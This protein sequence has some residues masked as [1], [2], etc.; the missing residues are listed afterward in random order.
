MEVSGAT[1]G[2]GSTTKLYIGTTSHPPALN[3]Q[4]KNYKM[5]Y[6]GL[7][8][9]WPYPTMVVVEYHDP[10]NNVMSAEGG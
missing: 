3:T 2:T 9:K 4:I 10:Q 7:T 1:L 8:K 6:A 5:I